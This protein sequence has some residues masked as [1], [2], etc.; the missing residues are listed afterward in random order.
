M[1]VTETKQPFTARE[2]A[3]LEPTPVPRTGARQASWRNIDYG[4]AVFLVASYRR[5]EVAVEAGSKRPVGA[6]S[7]C[8]G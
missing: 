2:D 8:G 7:K 4:E 5:P 6:N 1:P 3:S